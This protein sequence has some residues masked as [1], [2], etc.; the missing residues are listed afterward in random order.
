MIKSFPKWFDG[1]FG[2]YMKGSYIWNDLDL[3]QQSQAVKDIHF[4]DWA[5]RVWE[6]NEPREWTEAYRDYLVRFHAHFEVM[7][8]M[9]MQTYGEKPGHDRV[10]VWTGNT[11]KA[12]GHRRIPAWLR[13]SAEGLNIAKTGFKDKGF[14]DVHDCSRLFDHY[15]SFKVPDFDTNTYANEWVITN[16]YGESSWSKAKQ[17]AKLTGTIVYPIGP[18]PYYPK[19]DNCHAYIITPANNLLTGNKQPTT[20]N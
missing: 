12:S 11:Y 8:F 5:A 9:T 6:I 13:K 1:L 19:N 20:N 2:D 7:E 10:N 17:F 4:Y 3:L 18:A 15:G 14:A 16:P